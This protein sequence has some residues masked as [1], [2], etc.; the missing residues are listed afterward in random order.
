MERSQTVCI[1]CLEEATP[2]NPLW[3]LKCG[4]KTGWFHS[5]CE[6]MWLSSITSGSILCPACRRVVQLKTNYCLIYTAG[7]EQFRLWVCSLGLTGEL[8]YACVGAAL[9]YRNLLYLPASSAILLTL[10]FV[11]PRLIW[12]F[13]NYVIHLLIHFGLESSIFF[14]CFLQNSPYHQVID[15]QLISAGLHFFII[16]LIHIVEC[17]NAG[18]LVKTYQDLFSPYAISREILHADILFAIEPIASPTEGNKSRRR[19]S[20]RACAST[21]GGSGERQT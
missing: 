5:S 6:G 2:D 7:P 20:R 13:D 12:T 15:L 4:C 21:S 16:Y 8:F 14:L 3:L 11:S 9:G 19:R 17:Q 18:R 1:I 10:P